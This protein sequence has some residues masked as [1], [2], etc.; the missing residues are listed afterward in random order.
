MTNKSAIEQIQYMLKH[1][2]GNYVEIKKADTLALER[3][4]ESLENEDKI[5]HCNQCKYY[6]G[7]HNV[8]GHAPC[9]YW[10]TGGVLYSWFCSEGEKYD[11][12]NRY[13]S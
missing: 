3:A 7:V 8:P 9:S 5:I 1:K 4:L 12:T 6:E 10:K 11:A 2:V 13:N